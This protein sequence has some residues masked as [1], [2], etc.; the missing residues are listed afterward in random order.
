MAGR[1]SRLLHLGPPPPQPAAAGSL[2]CHWAKAARP[3]LPPPPP[4]LELLGWRDPVVWARPPE[5]AGGG[6][7]RL[8]VG[9]G[10]KGVGGLLLS[11][12]AEELDGGEG[13]GCSG[14]GRW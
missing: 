4:S 9:A 3:F 7:Y 1:L 13:L 5:P 10:A 8:T 11:Y 6:L 2:L 12:T 14:H